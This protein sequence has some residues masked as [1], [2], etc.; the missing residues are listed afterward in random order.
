V[1][2]K[3]RKSS[4]SFWLVFGAINV[5]VYIAGYIL[6]TKNICAPPADATASCKRAI[7]IWPFVLVMPAIWAIFYKFK[8]A[9]REIND[10]KAQRNKWGNWRP[11]Q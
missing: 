7:Q 3:P 4:L 5:A 1:T 10:Y 2:E 8:T 9:L 11:P 6:L